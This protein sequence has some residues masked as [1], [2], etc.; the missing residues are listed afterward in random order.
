MIG[1][2]IL[3]IYNLSHPQLPKMANIAFNVMMVFMFFTH[4][5]LLWVIQSA[6]KEEGKMLTRLEKMLVIVT[7]TFELM[8]L[9]RKYLP[10][11]KNQ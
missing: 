8:I 11:I 7:G 5:L 2:W 3:W 4:L 10:T 9:K 6:V 1:V